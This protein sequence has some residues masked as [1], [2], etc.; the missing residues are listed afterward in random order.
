M[1]MKHLIMVF[2]ALGMASLGGFAADLQ[3][4]ALS[5]DTVVAWGKS[6]DGLSVGISWVSS[7]GDSRT[8]PK[9]FFHVAND[10]AKE[11]PG[12][13]QN[14]AMCIVTMNGQHYAQTSWGGKSSWM[15]PGRKYGPIP[16]DTEKLR[17]ISDLRA[18]P[19]ITDTAPSFK[20]LEGTN[21]VALYYMLEKK[22]VKSG[23]IQIV[24]K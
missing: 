2:L 13:I 18:Y 14:G 19:V 20:L 3:S 23:E 22:L 11:I 5:S 16:I 24:A 21:T 17:Q 4:P 8:L 15:A 12:I 9:I 6:V 1:S 7:T 10:G